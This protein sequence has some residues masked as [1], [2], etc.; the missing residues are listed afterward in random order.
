MHLIFTPQVEYPKIADMFEVGFFH[1]WTVAIDCSSQTK[2]FFPAFVFSAFVA[3]GA[4]GG[5]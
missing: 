2:L 5:L 3:V 1:I 4:F